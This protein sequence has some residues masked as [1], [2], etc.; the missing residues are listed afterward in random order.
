MK[1]IKRKTLLKLAITGLIFICVVMFLKFIFNIETIQKN[2]SNY[3]II[4]KILN[5]LTTFAFSYLLILNTILAI[6][7]YE[8]YE[9]K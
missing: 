3:K 7:K 4:Q 5:F 6:K 2:I 8:G 1:I 9:I